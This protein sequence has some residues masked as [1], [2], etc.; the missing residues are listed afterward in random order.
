MKIALINNGP[1]KTGVGRYT[2]SIHNHLKK[3]IAIDHYF[4]DR[5]NQGL[6]KNGNAIKNIGKNIITGNNLFNN[7]ILSKLYLDFRMG[8]YIPEDYDLYHI[9]NQNLSILNYYP[10]IGK[11]IITAHDLIYF[12]YPNSQMQK[13]LSKF[14]Y[15]G[16]SKT[17]YV[18]SVSYFTKKN[19][20]KYG[21]PEDLIKVIHEG[22]DDNFKLLKEDELKETYLKYN[23][24]I[25]C[26]YILHVGSN[27]PRKN[28]EII[29]KAFKRLITHYDIKN[30]KLIKINH[31]DE[32]IIKNMGLEKHVI[33]LDYVDEEEL[34]KFYNIADVFVFPSLY[35]G[36][37]L[38]VLEAMACG[39]PVIAS[40]RSSIPEI[41]GDAGIVVDPYNFKDFSD[42]IYKV[43][44]DD[45]LRLNMVNKGIKR[46]KK[47]FTWENCA[48]ETLNV[49]KDVFK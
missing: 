17:D 6:Y 26:Y 41:L 43:L 19:L 3:T 40:N 2:V 13:I 14:L 9:A 15:K 28:I 22:V 36:F 29:L 48:K 25:N 49:Y 39:T 24:D 21:I 35:E 23:L 34:P 33:V 4:I 46:A 27:E 42:F 20:I 31:L 7:N 45:D 30:I 16:L 11:N 5:E 18:I 38:P 47:Y 1:F 44:K 8:R 37:G 12:T 32:K 10:N